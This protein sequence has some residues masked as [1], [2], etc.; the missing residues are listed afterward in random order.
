MG[1]FSVHANKNTASKASYPFL[2]DVQS[3]L[4]D[5]LETRMVVPLAPAG[6]YKGKAMTV[7]TPSFEIDQGLYVMLTPQMAGIVRKEMGVE[8]ADL[9]HHRQDIISAIDFLITGI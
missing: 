6:D 5:S 1:Q 9:S 7:L 4:L 3:Q 2:L 8:V